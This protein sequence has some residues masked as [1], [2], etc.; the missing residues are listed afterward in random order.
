ME[1]THQAKRVGSRGFTGSLK[2]PTV[3]A[4][5]PSRD[6]RMLGRAFRALVPK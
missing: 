2:L 6:A 5:S 3:S 1:P 4:E